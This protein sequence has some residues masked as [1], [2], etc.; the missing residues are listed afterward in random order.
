MYLKIKDG[1][2]EK[3]PYTIEELRADNPNVSFPANLAGVDL[4]PYG[5]YPVVAVPRPDAIGGVNWVSE[6]APAYVDGQ[7]TQVWIITT[8]T[9]EEVTE[10]TAGVAARARAERTRRLQECDWTQ[11]RDVQLTNDAA[12][13]AY[14]QAL[15]DISTQPGF[16]TSIDW[17]VKPV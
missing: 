6:G 11:G 7:W 16:P 5:V 3:Y 13:V 10:I 15:R 14:R 12:W 9:P 17:P 8:Y 2:I 4:E 1:A